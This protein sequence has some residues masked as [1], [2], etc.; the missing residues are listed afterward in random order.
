MVNWPRVLGHDQITDLYLL[1]L[2]VAHDGC[3]VTLDHRVSTSTIVGASDRHLL[4]L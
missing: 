1:A 2:A 4:L 3:L